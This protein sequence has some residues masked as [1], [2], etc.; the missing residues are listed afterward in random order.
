MPRPL[1]IEFADALFHVT[2]RGVQKAP[3]VTDDHDRVRWMEYLKEA[4]LRFALELYAFVLMDNHFHL[5]VSTPRANLH[6]AMQY[7]NG[8]YAMYFNVR[9][10]RGG[11]LFERRY[12]SILIENQGHYTEVSRYVHLNPVR[13]RLAERPEEYPWSSYAGYHWGR[14]PLSWVNYER[15]LSE[16]G[17][18]KDARRRYRE[19]VADGTDR[20]LPAPWLEAVGG[21]LL[22]SPGFVAKVYGMLSSGRS[23][24]R[25]NSRAAIQGKPLDVLPDEIAS[26]VC[27][28]FG[29]SNTPLRT[30]GTNTRKARSAFVLI[31]RDRAGMSLKAIASYLNAP[32]IASVS[33][34]AG[35]ARKRKSR[36]ADD[37]KR[38]HHIERLVKP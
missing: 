7:L 17:D 23:G 20:K 2:A 26:A 10:E 36:D 5:F 11:H 27:K 16:F 15:V 6:K 24:A 22:G 1:R 33:K 28:V 19:F 32:G 37:R 8:S 3:I 30:G 13:A 34:I 38:L 35:V 25:W 14:M 4:V 18:G 31:A 29:I 21:W 12:R 9:H